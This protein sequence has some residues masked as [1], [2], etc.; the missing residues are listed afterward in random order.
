ML[1]RIF[2]TNVVLTL[3]F[4]VAATISS[5]QVFAQ[6]TSSSITGSV[7]DAKGET[8][9]GASVIAIHTPSGSRYGASTNSAGR[10]TL[11]SVRVGGPFKITVSF[12]GYKTEEFTEVYTT[13]GVATSLNIKL[14][15]E[16]KQLTEVIVKGDKND[17]FSSSRTGA[18]AS[19]SGQT[20]STLPTL[21]RT[22]NSITKYNAYSNGSSFAGQDSRFN[23]FTI[24]GSVFNNGF[25]LGNEA[26]AGGRTGYG[27]ISLDAVEQLQINI[28]P[29]DVRQSGFAGAAINAVTR[30]GTNETTGSVYHFWK[31]QGLVGNKI[32]TTS[33][34]I[35]NF[36]EKTT[37]FRVGG[38]IIKNKLF[39]FVNGEFID[40]STPALSWSANRGTS[41]ANISRTT[42][43]D[44]QKVATIMNKLGWD[45]G[46]FDGF[47][48][49]SNSKKF[50]ARID[51]N[52]NDKHKLTVRYSHHDSQSD[53]LI[54]GSN[55][56]GTA[57]FGTR[58][59]NA[60]SL[61]PQNTGYIILDNT[62]SIVAEL[63][64]TFNSRIANN[65]IATYNK[66]IEDR[67]YRTSL[68]PLIEIQDPSTVSTYTTAGMDPFTPSNK[69]D[70]STLNFTDN[71]TYFAG[72]HTVTAGLSY[73]YFKSNN[74]FF[75]AS[76]G[77][78]VYKSMAD[79]ETAMNAYIA[80]PNLTTS[81]VQLAR[82]NYRYSLLPDGQ[83]PWQV[84]KV[85]TASAYLQDEFQAKDNLKLT[86][87]LR[88]DYI[89][90]GTEIDYYNASVAALTYKAPDG[91][92]YKVNTG[93]MPKGRV[94]LSPRFGFNWDVKNDK[95]TQ[96]RGGTGLFL[97]RMPYVLISNQLG[98]NGVNTA[99]LTVNNTTAYPFTL[100]PSKYKPSTTNLDAIPAFTLNAN[101][102]NLK[103]PQIWKSN[104]A[105]DQKLPFGFIGTVEYIYNQN[106]NALKYID[107]NLKAPT[108]TFTGA[109]NRDRY[110]R[111]VAS[112]NSL[113][114]N[115]KTNSAYILTNT[116][117]GYSYSFT[118]KLEKPV[119]NG[120]GGMFAYTYSMAKDVASVGSTVDATTPTV[121]GVNYL[122][123]DYSNNDLRHRF[124]GYVNYSINYGGKFGG[125]TTFTL[126]MV[127]N[128]G[129]KL[130]YTYSTDLNGDGQ[131]NND[132]IYIPKAGSTLNFITN[133]SFTPAQ[134][135]A[136][137][138][139]WVDGDAYLSSRRGNY[140]ER[141]GQTYPWLTRFDFTVEQDFFV[142]TGS[143][144]NILRFRADILNAGNLIS[145]TAGIGYSTTTA[146]PLTTG[147][148]AQGNITYRLATQV[149]N[150]KSV[151]LQDRFV[152]NYSLS[153]LYQIQL[154]VRYIFN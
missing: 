123:L 2:T 113:Y 131:T 14:S 29:F 41:G 89:T 49:L 97:S 59:N 66:Q 13:L 43:A 133:G 96:V 122:G 60:Q 40:S 5:V 135:Q 61:S 26:Q 17:V 16:G 19:F 65:F 78:Y 10:F 121:R 109:D 31:N 90:I 51:Y 9:P 130:S 27:A 142:K 98:N 145:N 45:S 144:T 56:S 53:Q 141:N 28:A 67:K 106:I 74:L 34:K 152:K 147:L 92:D 4:A 32:D 79:F 94:Y 73:E 20:L 84:I 38:A 69:L 48:S 1:K 108:T 107:V 39:Y 101:D 154:G 151:L 24:D 125:A 132:L 23:N 33:I 55:S 124:V 63:N 95:K 75:P 143:K 42:L 140:V 86:A 120:L 57:G 93:A 72:K 117:Q 47:N 21:S 71:L 153:S 128:S 105:V 25:G 64:S 146:T 103:F 119:K 11:P 6:V 115:S 58:A 110:P 83:E 3:L 50:L 44:M 104:I 82:F 30:S 35:T 12:V 138:D 148:D 149:V 62:R 111:S 76:Q 22:I 139:A 134:Q 87:G 77:V 136:A 54:S 46:A 52:I 37:G 116:D 70:Y 18:A 127:S 81:P 100:D 68:F 80:N 8:L 85:S 150:G 102:E 91:S 114:I 36:S 7:V 99:V 88:A 129:S 112:A 15:E 137:F 126:G 118:A